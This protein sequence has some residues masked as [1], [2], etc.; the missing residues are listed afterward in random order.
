MKAGQITIKKLLDIRL[1][2]KGELK[3]LALKKKITLTDMVMVVLDELL[4][5]ENEEK[6]NG[7]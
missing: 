2:E 1:L 7:S 5:R 4:E 3:M 6:E